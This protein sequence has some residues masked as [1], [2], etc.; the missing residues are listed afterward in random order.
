VPTTLHR[1]APALVDAPCTG[2]R[3][4]SATAAVWDRQLTVAVDDADAL[5][6]ALQVA[7]RHLDG[8][9]EVVDRTRLR[10]QVHLLPRADGEPV[11][12]S[13]LLARHVAT[14]LD[15]ARRTRGLVDPTV[16]V[17][18]RPGAAGRAPGERGPAARREGAWI[19]VC[20]QS[21]TVRPAPGWRVVDVRGSSV[22]VPGGTTLELGPGA[23]ALALDDVALV[24]HQL[25]GAHVLVRLG[26]RAA[27]LGHGSAVAHPERLVDPRTGAP[28]PTTW[29]TVEVS[30]TSCR[31]ASSLALAAAVLGP[32]APQWLADRGA[33]AVLVEPTGGVVRVGSFRTTGLHQAA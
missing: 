26:S 5:T 23:R 7:R 22:R 10:A 3:A 33:D 28:A 1:I 11:S 16:V 32:L 15:T 8:V 2:G 21:S 18:R 31:I 13:P 30:A 9:A 6:P 19:P 17:A 25:T 4:R 14:A 12:V 24:A 27:T 20:G 29:R